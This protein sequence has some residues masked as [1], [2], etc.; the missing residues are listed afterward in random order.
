MWRYI[1][2][3]QHTFCSTSKKSLKKNIFKIEKILS[4]KERLDA[5][6][7]LQLL[8]SKNYGEGAFLVAEIPTD[9]TQTVKGKFSN[10]SIN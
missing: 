10:L 1:N 2:E 7:E 8:I 4:K 9:L 3:R 5:P 6:G